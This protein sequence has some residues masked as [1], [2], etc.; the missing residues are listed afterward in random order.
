MTRPRGYL[1]GMPETLH[2]DLT[3]RDAKAT[4]D[5][6]RR[7]AAL[8]RPGDTVLLGGPI[9]AGKTHLARAAIQALLAAEGRHEDVPSPTFTLVQTY[10]LAKGEVVH[11]D[12]YRL[13]GPEGLDD[14][15]LSDQIGRA[16]C[17]IEWPDRLGS[18]APPE[19]LGVALA[20]GAAPDERLATIRASG[21]RW[22]A[23]GERLASAADRAA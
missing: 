5:L 4:A 7:L 20:H 9:G 17:L 2:L 14:I 15:G 13:G 23:A 21:R 10:D 16:I 8:L 3:L 12:L 22:A 1:C 11:A 18:L 6:G 19:A